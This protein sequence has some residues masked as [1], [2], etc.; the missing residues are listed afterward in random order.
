MTPMSAIEREQLLGYILG[1][2]DGEEHR[3]VAARLQREPELFHNLDSVRRSLR[4]LQAVA[5]VYEPPAG[6]AE[7]TCRMVLAARGR[8]GPLPQLS[9]C[10]P[11]P[12]WVRRFPFADVAMGIAV[13][14]AAVA[15]IV[16]AIQSSRFNAQILTCQDKLRQIGV[17]LTQYSEQHGGYFP[18]VPPRGR[19]ATA[20]IYAP[21]LL[22]HGLLRES[23]QV[24]CPGSPLAGDPEF[25]VPHLDEVGQAGDSRG[26]EMCRR[27]GGSYGYTLGHIDNGVY[28]GTKN[29]RRV[30]FP[31]LSDTPSLHMPQFQSVNHSGEGQNVLFED[32]HV[33][34]LDVPADPGSFDH[35]FTN[36]EGRI[37]PGTH[38]DDSVIV[39]S[40][41]Y[42][43]VI[44][45]VVEPR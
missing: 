38:P 40:T 22:E 35:L 30:R 14:L 27:M 7:R 15:L 1:A 2:L 8:A 24:V 37:A 20:G 42:P 16:P 33:R 41:V 39:S 23:Q 17:A 11:P 44:D 13:L 43:L 5:R 12:R 21:V 34:F 6:L 10:A 19:F 31:L 9:P 26:R 32:G 36:E 28:R 18:V 4:P 29:L 45:G 25:R 3:H